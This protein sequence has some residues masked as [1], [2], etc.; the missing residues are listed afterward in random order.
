M[1]KILLI[2][3]LPL[4]IAFVFLMYR[5]GSP[6]GPKLEQ[7][8]HLRT[9][10]IVTLPAQKVLQVTAQG[11]PNV[12]AKKAFGLLMKTYF[13]LKNVPKGGPD[14]KA[15]RARWQADFSAPAGQWVGYYAMPVPESIAKLPAVKEA[16]GLTVQLAM[17]DYGQVAEVLYVGSYDQETPT[18][19][20][21]KDFIERNG[22]QITGLHE[23]EYLRGPGMLFAGDPATY[24]TIIRYQVRKKAAL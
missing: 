14:F 17:W 3:G 11:E 22:Y 1:K 24:L 21:L 18:I 12:V 10:H 9:A 23:E 16:D 2:I 8:A 6:Q 19:Q 13:K 20:A 5:F 7:V 4:F 15:P